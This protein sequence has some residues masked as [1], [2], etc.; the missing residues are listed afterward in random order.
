M[1]GTHTPKNYPPTCIFQEEVQ[2]ARG[3]C[4]DKMYP[5]VYKNNIS[6]CPVFGTSKN[7]VPFLAIDWTISDWQLTDHGSG[8]MGCYSVDIQ[9]SSVDIYM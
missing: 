1:G 2:G 4:V 7:Y 9:F 8:K 5:N 3:A 6:K